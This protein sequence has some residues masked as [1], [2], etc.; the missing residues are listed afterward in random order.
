MKFVQH[1]HDSV[2]PRISATT[3]DID[4]SFVPCLCG[5]STVPIW[6]AMTIRS[7]D[8]ISRNEGMR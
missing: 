5:L 8:E 7:S 1:V 3:I 2:Q 6:N 4:Q